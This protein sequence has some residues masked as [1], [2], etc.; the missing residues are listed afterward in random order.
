M[1]RCHAQTSPSGGRAGCARPRGGG[2]RR[3]GPRSASERLARAQNGD[4][5]AYS[6]APHGDQLRR[7]RGT[8][9][10]SDVF[11]VREGGKPILVAGRGAGKTWNACPAFSPDGTKLAFGTKSPGRKAVTVVR[12][13]RAGVSAAQRVKLTVRGGDGLAPCPIW[14]ADGS[15]IGIRHPGKVVVRGLDGSSSA[16]GPVT[17]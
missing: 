11:L 3:C 5:I 9:T 16:P 6:T 14:S 1:L 12:V 15:R 8:L 10:G 13:T 4:W 7:G 17:P 2:D